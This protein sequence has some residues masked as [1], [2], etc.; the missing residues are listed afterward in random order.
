MKAIVV[1]AAIAGLGGWG[2]AAGAAQADRASVE[3]LDAH[4]KP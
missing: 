1:A 2:S 4:L 3:F